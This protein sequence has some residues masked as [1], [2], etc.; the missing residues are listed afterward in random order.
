[1]TSAFLKALLPP[2]L[3]VHDPVEKAD[4]A[5]HFQAAVV[6]PRAQV[7]QA[8]AALDVLVQVAD[9]RLDPLVAGLGSDLNHL[10]DP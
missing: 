8:A 1:L 3:V 9:P 7:L 6:D 4:R 5:F 10:H 2:P